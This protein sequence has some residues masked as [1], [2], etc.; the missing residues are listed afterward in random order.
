MVCGRCLLLRHLRSWWT[1][2]IK[3][4]REFRRR[5]FGA[6]RIASRRMAPRLEPRQ[7]S[8]LRLVAVDR[9]RV[10]VAPTRVGDMVDAAA[11]RPIRPCIIDIECKGSVDR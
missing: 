8:R 10:V 1:P 9:K 4:H 2:E 3:R 7:A 11:D 6:Q 5:A